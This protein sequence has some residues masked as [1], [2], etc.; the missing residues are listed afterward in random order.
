MSV[1]DLQ[2]RRQVTL[3]VNFQARLHARAARYSLPRLP[4]LYCTTFED[5]A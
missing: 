3:I 1:L 4:R 2:M 5:S